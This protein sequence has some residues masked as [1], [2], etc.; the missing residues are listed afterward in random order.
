MRAI[1]IYVISVFPREM[2]DHDL[3]NKSIKAS[4]LCASFH[5][6]YHS[7]S[8]RLVWAPFL[9]HALGPLMVYVAAPGMYANFGN[10]G[11]KSLRLSA[12]WRRSGQVG[13]WY[14]C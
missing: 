4:L 13:W 3:S 8:L 11:Q 1:E 7:R 5:T 9:S 12:R 14:G 6:A 2:I 10:S